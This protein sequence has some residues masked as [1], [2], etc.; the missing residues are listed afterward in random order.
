MGSMR[1]L[2]VGALL[3]LTPAA[4]HAQNLLPSLSRSGSKYALMIDGAPFLILGAQTHNSSNYPAELPKVWPVIHELHANTLEIP[5]AWEQI[6]PRE[7][8]FDFAWVDSLLPE[9]RRNGVRLILLWFG[10]FKNTSPSYAP[11]WVKSDTRRFARMTTK[12]G[13]THYVLS[14]HSPTTLKADSGAFAALMH[15]IRDVDAQHT[16]IM[17]H[18]ENETRQLSIA[19]GF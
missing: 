13:K 15:H 7:G 2:L 5:V 18:V 19:P 14:P 17:V 1:S 11:E 10:A 12:D 4:L 8:R 16:V 9:A 3:A 6:E